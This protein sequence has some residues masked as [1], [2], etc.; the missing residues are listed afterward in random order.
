MFDDD[1]SKAVAVMKYNASTEVSIL[2]KAAKI[3]QKD[4]LHARQVFTGSFSHESEAESLPTT[5]S[6]FLHTLLDEPH[7][8]NH[9]SQ[10]S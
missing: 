8:L 3:L 10:I 5:L 1:L 9:R 6:S 7:I 2:Y 4:C